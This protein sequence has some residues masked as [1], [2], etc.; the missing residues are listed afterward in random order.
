MSMIDDIKKGSLTTMALGAGVLSLLPALLPVAARGVRPLLNSAIQGSL[1]CLEKGQEAVA[2]IHRIL[3][4]VAAESEATSYGTSSAMGGGY[5]A[6]SS[7][8]TSD[9]SAAPGRP[10]TESAPIMARNGE[11]DPEVMG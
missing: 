2:E 7:R 9:W 4:H 8:T 5:H 6:A 3:D 1:V 11:P 10:T